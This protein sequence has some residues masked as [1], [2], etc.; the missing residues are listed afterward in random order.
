MGIESD[1]LSAAITN[2]EQITPEWLRAVLADTYLA[3]DD[4]VVSCSETQIA[5]GEGFSDVSTDCFL[6]SIADRYQYS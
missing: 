5:I 3:K 6:P 4:F 1:D 2:I